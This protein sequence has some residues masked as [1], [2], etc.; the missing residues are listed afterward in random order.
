MKCRHLIPALGIVVTLGMTS[1]KAD[2]SYT[3]NADAEG[4]QNVVWQA[5]A[6]AG[7]AGGASIR[8]THT[9]GGW[10]V[11]LTKEFSFEAGGGA[12]NQQVEMQTFA[13]QGG[14][15]AFD[16]MIDGG[17]FPAGAQTWFQL[18]LVGNSD[19]AAGW[20]QRENVFT[21]SGWHNA[22]DATLVTLHIDQPFSYFGWDAGDRWFQLYTGTNSDGPVPVNFYIDNLTAYVPV[23][24]EP[25]SFALAILGGA[26]LLVARRRR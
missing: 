7:W 3:F 11:L 15:L 12:A 6:P 19:G 21:P 26:G 5:A 23:V 22:D 1:A 13:S 25:S 10:Q 8:Q 16:V 17:S 18:H 14:R 2:L 4:F 20:T 9:A 24:P